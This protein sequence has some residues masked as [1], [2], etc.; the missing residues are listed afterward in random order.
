MVFRKY[1]EDLEMWNDLPDS[2]Q[3][4][5]VGRDKLT[6][7]FLN[8]REMWTPSV[9]EKTSPCAHIRRANP[10]EVPASHPDHWK[11]RIYR[12]GLKFIEQRRDG[13]LTYGLLFIALVRDPE[14]QF[15]RIHNERM[16]PTVGSKD[17]FL[18]SG[19]IKPLHSSCYYLPT[20]ARLRE[21]LKPSTGS[22][23][24]R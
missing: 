12:R 13:D 17:H 23:R 1:E 2:V 5:F 16:L 15:A 4:F 20:P 9:W 8:G 24:K 19:Y 10:R 6:G 22:H 7:R 3:E 11:E 21:L 18:S 14:M